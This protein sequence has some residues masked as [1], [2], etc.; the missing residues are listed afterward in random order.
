MA[1][2]LSE[3][4][5]AC[6]ISSSPEALVCLLLCKGNQLEGRVTNH[7]IPGLQEV[8]IKLKSLSSSA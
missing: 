2:H 6:G 7:M 3:F 5:E 8:T 4:G 1:F